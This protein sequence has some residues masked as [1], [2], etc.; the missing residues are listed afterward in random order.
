M[1]TPLTARGLRRDIPYLWEGKDKRGRHVTGKSVA[2]SEVALRAELRNQGIAPTRLRR[3]STRGRG[4]KVNTLDIA[5][6]SRQLATMLAAGI[7]MVFVPCWLPR[8][9][10]RTY[11]HIYIMRWKVYTI[12]VEYVFNSVVFVVAP[13]RGVGGRDGGHRGP[14][15]LCHPAI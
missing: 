8:T 14:A 4:G 15:H 9:Y 1:A 11:R 7:P 3:Q 2:A 13:G 6:F 5:V 12:Y 10:A